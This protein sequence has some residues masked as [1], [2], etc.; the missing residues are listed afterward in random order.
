MTALL[1]LVA[2]GIT[3]AGIAAAGVVLG[4]T[5]R[6]AAALPVFLEFLLAAGLLRLAGDPTWQR[7]VTT[8][9]IALLRSMVGRGLRYGATAWTSAAWT[10][11]VPRRQAPTER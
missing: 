11:P 3:A 4:S 9:V 2:L 8:A 5:R 10:H 6:P 1:D 7:I